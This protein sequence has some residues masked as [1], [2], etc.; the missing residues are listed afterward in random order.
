MTTDATVKFAAIQM[1]SSPNVRA[2]LLEAERLIADAVRMGARLVVLPENFA[3]MARM[4]R[5]KLEVAEPDGQGPIQDFL[6]TQ[7]QRHNIWLVGG[8]IP[9]QS[10]VAGKV[11]AACLVYDAAGQRV[12]RYDKMHLFDVHLL[13]TDE[14]YHESE[15]IDAGNQTCVIDTPCG[16]LG[17]AVCYDL[18]FPEIFRA[19]LD[20]G[21]EM[22]AI[23]SAF[24]ALTGKAHWELLVRTRAVENLCFVV[25]AAQG[26]Y[27]V[28][29]RETHGHTMIVDPWGVILD[30]LQRV[31]GVAIASYD[32]NRLLNTRRTFPAIT[33][34]RLKCRL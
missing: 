12:A 2:N 18:R 14:Q 10:Q 16:R 26:G 34:R 19:M 7:A 22:L 30:Q 13:D 17:I 32:R 27:H 25:A 31:P 28:G 11:R 29:G 5:D 33:H 3:L 21:M 1:A 4:E 8:T 23:P 9:M 15:T 6:A 20:Q 24:T